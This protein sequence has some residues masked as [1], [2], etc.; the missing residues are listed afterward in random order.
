M[1]RYASPGIAWPLVPPLAVCPLQAKM[2]LW[3]RVFN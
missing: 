3:E 2:A 1:P